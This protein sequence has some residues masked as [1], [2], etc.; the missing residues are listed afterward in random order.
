MDMSIITI[1]VKQKM[2]KLIDIGEK[3]KQ[4]IY[5]QIHEEFGIPRVMIRRIARE[6]RQDW[7]RKIAILQQDSHE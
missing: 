2:E 7:A 3:D 5:E 6:L 1:A 4:K